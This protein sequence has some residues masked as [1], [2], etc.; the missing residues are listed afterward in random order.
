[1]TDRVVPLL[2]PT[3]DQAVF[4]S[5]ARNVVRVDGPPPNALAPNATDFSSLA[6]LGTQSFFS[7]SDRHRVVV[8]FTDGESVPFDAAALATGLSGTSVVVVRLWGGHERVYVNGVAAPDYRPDPASAELTQ[9]LAS[10]TG[11]SA[12]SAGQIR[13]AAEAVRQSAG[14]GPTTNAAATTRRTPL[15]PWLALLAL[16]PLAVL[17]WRR[18]FVAL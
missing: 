2:M 14:A 1:M 6:A 15:A 13:N 7:P 10:A 11:G 3:S 9:E 8:V 12:F 17:A 18:L 5:V 4:D 16:V